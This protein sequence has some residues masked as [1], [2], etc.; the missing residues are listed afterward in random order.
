[1]YRVRF[2]ESAERGL[3]CLDKPVGARVVQRIKWLVENLDSI[4]PKRLTGGLV[5]LCK[6]REGDYR[7]SIRCCTRRRRSSFTVLATAGTSTG[8]S[9]MDPWFKPQNRTV[10][11]GMFMAGVLFL[12]VWPVLRRPTMPHAHRRNKRRNRSPIGWI[13]R[14]IMPPASRSHN[15]LKFSRRFAA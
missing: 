5:G 1:M 7:I 14:N 2:L 4:K 3:E 6:L 8:E 11:C 13:G 12:G 15:S 10:R 9:R